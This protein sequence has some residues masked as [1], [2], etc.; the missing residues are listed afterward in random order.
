MQDLGGG[1]IFANLGVGIFAGFIVICCAY[2]FGTSS[3]ALDFLW[4]LFVAILA[5]MY[6]SFK[7]TILIKSSSLGGLG[8]TF[9][10]TVVFILSL[11]V[12]IMEGQRYAAEA[13]YAKGEQLLV[14]GKIEQ[15]VA[16]IENAIKINP[17]SDLYL[18][19]LSQAYL[20]NI[21][22]VLADKSLTQDQMSQKVKALIGGAVNSAKAATDLNPKNVANWS[23]QGYVYQN[24][25]GIV[26][27]SGD[28]SQ[29]SYEQALALEPTNPYFLVQS[30]LS[31]IRDAGFLGD[32]KKEDKD[33]L[34]QSG[35]V[36]LQKAIDLKQDYGL[37][38]L[39][40]ALLYEAE[41]KKDEALKE[42]ITAR[43]TN[44]ADP[45][46]AFQLGAMLYRQADYDNAIFELERTVSLSQ[47]YSNALYLLTI[48]YDK[49]GQQDKAIAVIKKVITL[50]PGNDQVA[51]ILDNLQAGR[52]ALSGTEGQ[53]P[54]SPAVPETPATGAKPEAPSGGKT[55]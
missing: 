43:N 20:S 25:I 33:K 3:L 32:D 1:K 55:K 34:L 40:L 51:K 49:K 31:A 21:N 12:F 23:V 36:Y 42:M 46:L 41:N 24:L 10:L 38:H 7:K 47:N 54:V 19:E 52:P 29:K 17:N 30:A 15:A 6:S 4:F 44:L 48:C 2:F 35:Q 28:W 50:N 39:Q 22:Q 9:A 37:A 11:G 27:G 14:A 45:D 26:A 18:R 5:G 53:P 13:Y 8:I 16:S